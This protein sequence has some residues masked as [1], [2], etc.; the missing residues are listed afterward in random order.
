VP[1]GASNLLK[2][3]NRM[4]TRR[5]RLK[6]RYMLLA[7]LTGALIGVA[8]LAV[9]ANAHFIGTP[10]FTDQG[11]TLNATGRIAGLG[12]TDTF[13]QLSATGVPTV[14]CTTKGGNE[15]PG[16]NPGAITVIGGQPIPASDVKNG[17]LTFNVTTAEPGP[18]TGKQG[19]CPNNNWTA[20]ITDVAFT[21]ATITV[22]QG[23]TCAQ[24]PFTTPKTGCDQVVIQQTFTL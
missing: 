1:S 22:F 18:I 15:A 3:E 6:F 23:P 19:G 11:K 14:T 24:P 2:K 21:S 12:N 5:L 7:A 10:T 20:T 17:N 8:A 4:S 16:Q 9:A 13:I